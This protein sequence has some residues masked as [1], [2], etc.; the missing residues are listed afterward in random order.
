M[1]QS[2][3]S[4]LRSHPG[5]TLGSGDAEWG[6]WH[7]LVD[8]PVAYVVDEAG[9]DQLVWCS[10]RV[11]ESLDVVMHGPG[12]VGDRHCRYFVHTEA[13]SFCDLSLDGRV[14]ETRHS[15]IGV[16]DNDKFQLPRAASWLAEGGGQD[17][18]NA[19]ISH[20]CGGDPTACVTNDDCVAESE[21][22]EMRRIDAGVNAGQDDR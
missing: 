7:N 9:D 18:E 10:G 13:E 4:F 22:E 12:G 21:P 1:R 14:G 3:L 6:R 17:A 15:A 2:F 19:E 5:S 16:V 11:A 20:H 8:R